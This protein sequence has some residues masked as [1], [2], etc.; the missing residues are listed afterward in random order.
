MDAS[1][2]KPSANATP[3]FAT[4]AA[5]ALLLGMLGVQCLPR[6]P[7]AWSLLIVACVAALLAWRL[8][9]WR[10]V[11][12]VLM[13]FAW[14]AFRASLAL[15][16]RL[17]RALE[18]QDIDVVGV[19][20]DLPR[21]G[22][23][24]WR[25][26][27]RIESASHDGSALSLRGLARVSWYTKS[28]PFISSCSRW[29]M[30]LRLK[31]PRGSVNPGGFDFER[32]ALQRGIVA[33]GY[34]RDEGPNLHV[35]RSLLC[36]DTL[37]DSVSQGIAARVVN[38]RDAHLLQAFAVGDT[39]GL[40]DHDWDVAR[41]NGIPHLLAISGFHV[42]VAAG[43]GVFL[44]RGLWWLWPSLALRWPAR[45][46]EAP[47]AL[48]FALA[49][50]LLAGGSL[51][52]VR[53]LIMIA[54]IVLARLGRRAV[55]GLQSLAL[56]L[57]AIV[58][59]DP[60]A[61]LSAGF[62]L[63]FIGVAFLMLCLSRGRGVLGF[64]R[65]LGVAQLVMTVS[66]LPLTAWFF[67][68]SSL[69]GTLSNLVAVPLVSFAI[70]PLTLIGTL[71]LLSAPAIAAPP[72]ILAGWLVHAMWALL[73]HLATWPGAH[74]Y[75]PGVDVIAVLLAMLGAIWLFLPR[76]VP[77]RLL[78]LAL[79]LP[80]LR[81]QLAQPDEG[82]FTAWM[83]DVGQGLSVL[84]RTRD[85]ALLYDAGARYPSGF[86]LG[87]AAVLPTLRTLG[88]ER[89]DMIMISHGDNDHAGGAAAVASA[90]PRAQRW[91]GEPG[92]VQLSMSQC[93][94]GQAWQWNGVS[95]RVLYPPLPAPDAARG[96]RADN[97]QSCV[98]LVES[99]GG[100]LLLTGD[101]S[102]ASEPA[103]AAQMDGI[104]PLVV[105]VPHHGSKT[106][107]SADFIAALKP[108]LAVVSAG[109]RSRFGHPHPDVVARYRAAGVPFV[110]TADSGALRV[111]FDGRSLQPQRERL[112]QPRYWRE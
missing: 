53:T 74:W 98:L 42:G 17:P 96:G 25:F 20:T 57:I 1:A 37:R 83:I 35:G 92:R 50:G 66:L 68:Q 76:G 110:N 81:P 75:P 59:V 2:S 27:V 91:S 108:R 11:V 62:W 87:E 24:A 106:S 107:S 86:D 101:I 82:A 71:L 49:Y 12:I 10:L 48:I 23:N 31:R 77:A 6:L 41:A 43:F 95:L 28:D 5:L 55:G 73:D 44:M 29:H 63:S 70:V 112:Q 93:H 69:V 39:R 47:A 21:R 38:A 19:I 84:V 58:L 85:H 8:P 100:R 102:R 16:A 56:A 89:L 80:L 46:V 67:G 109:W 72:L 30:R 103:V 36:I 22:A 97:D 79:F 94:A 111:D 60:L 40:D 51:P 15:D 78:G 90:Y 7:P 65:E 61:I 64:A 52:T 88:V 9:R 34:I 104:T 45:V 26:S 4:R 18:G 33:T 32:F 3:N 14:C 13:G 99:T 105:Q 54:V